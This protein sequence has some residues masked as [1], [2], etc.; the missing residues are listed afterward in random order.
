MKINSKIH[1]VIDYLVVVFLWLSPSIFNLP[2]L[3]QIFTYTLGGIHLGLTLFTNFELGL[4]K[5]IPF[6]IHGWIELVVSI[7]LIGVAFYLGSIDGEFSRN[8]YLAFAI[9]VFLTWLLTD[10]GTK[11]ASNVEVKV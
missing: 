2:E 11:H 10:Y 6:K 9:A 8:Y 1:G 5:V 4:L 7:A 3:T